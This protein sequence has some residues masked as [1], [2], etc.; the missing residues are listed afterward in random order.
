MDSGLLVSEINSN[1]PRKS[2]WLGGER[3]T[4]V[5]TGKET[6]GQFSQFDLFFPSQSAAIPHTHEFTET[7]YILEGELSFQ[8]GEQTFTASAGDTVNVLKGQLHGWRNIGTTPA[9]AIVIA[10][11]SGIED[12]F[13]AVGTPGTEVPPQVNEKLLAA[14]STP[15]FGTKTADSLI[16]TA[17]EYSVNENGIP[18]AEIT[19][20]RPGSSKGTVSATITLNDDTAKLSQD[21]SKTQIS[22]DF[23]DGEQRKTVTIPLI[24]DNEIEANETIDLTLNDPQGSTSVGLLQDK[25]TLTIFDDDAR[26]DGEKRVSLAGDNEN[27][28]LTGK[29]SS[30]N[31]AGGKGNDTL[32]GNGS[33]DLF[34][35]ALGDGFDTITDFGGVGKGSNPSTNAIEEIDTLKFE[36][37]GLTANNMLLT[38]NGSDLQITFEEVENTE[39]VLKDFALQDL[40]N[41]RTATG[42][43]TDYGNVLFDGQTGF[44]DSFDIFDANRQSD[45]IFNP[46]SVTFLNNLDN[47]TSGFD[48]SKDVINGQYGNDKLNGLSGDDLLRGGSNNDILVGGFGK[49]T[50]VGGSGKDLFSFT[51]RA[52]IDTITDFTNGQD[53]IELSDGLKFTDL[54]VIQGTGNNTD[55]TLISIASSNELLTTLNGVSASTITI[56]DFTIA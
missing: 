41:L 3:V 38:Q 2:F 42:G 9:R 1:E 47:N 46:N 49:D 31:I 6:N 33:R 48:N 7:F 34:T 43:S 55:D 44:Q 4:F 53:L 17:N 51:F 13:E 35:V 45:S 10:T 11:P 25:A 29:D 18:I 30:E 37:A 56:D 14:A 54:T 40:D 27:N 52:G 15:M 26:P 8:L 39:V 21:Y 20:L 50:L 23:A 32:T 19:L 24:D 22:V 5:A 12:L 36:G 16:F 28:I